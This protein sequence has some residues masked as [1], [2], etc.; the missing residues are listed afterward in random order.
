MTTPAEEFADIL[1]EDSVGTVGAFT[2]W[3][4]FISLP[5][6]NDLGQDSII[7]CSDT[8]GDPPNPNQSLDYSTVQVM[9][10]GNKAAYAEAY[11]RAKLVK[12]SLLGI[13][14]RTILGVRYAGIW[15]IGDI[16]SIGYDENKRPLLTTNWR[17]MREPPASGNRT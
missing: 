13:G 7:T 6:T 4:I 8:G 10:R 11:A 1:A 12:D 3:G 5:P 2:G 16:T 17:T 15:M 9:I 14:D